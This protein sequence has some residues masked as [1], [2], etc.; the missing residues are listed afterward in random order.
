MCIAE[1]SASI[2]QIEGC[3]E[4][5]WENPYSILERVEQN[6]TLYLMGIHLDSDDR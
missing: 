4:D 2:L 6:E 1:I 5:V 3:E